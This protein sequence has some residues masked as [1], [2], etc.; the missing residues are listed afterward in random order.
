MMQDP[1][2]LSD[3][4]GEPEIARALRE[5]QGDVLSVDAVARVRAALTALPGGPAA[6]PRSPMARLLT[7]ATPLRIGLAGLVLAGL[8]LGGAAAMR[9][10][11]SPPVALPAPRVD[12]GSALP[13]EE[14]SVPPPADAPPAS[15]PSA[16]TVGAAR[17]RASAR[18]S[19]TAA[20]PTPREGALLLEARRALD[21]DP[22]RALALV[23]AHEQEFPASQLRSERARIAAEAR[24][25]LER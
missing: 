17:A 11:P 6:G 12:Q 15:V 19:S 3:D 14:V 8:G 5:A 1:P 10:A 25:R 18:P 20:G 24:Q 4:P 23:R 2:R 22:A 13:P 16:T 9:H 7:G 21:G